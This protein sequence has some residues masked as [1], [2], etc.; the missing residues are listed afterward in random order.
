[1]EIQF[2]QY[3]ST[4]SYSVNFKVIQCV[5]LAFLCNNFYYMIFRSIKKLQIKSVVG[6]DKNINLF[7]SDN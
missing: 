3:K 7:K 4:K 2:K 6:E 1:M 5:I